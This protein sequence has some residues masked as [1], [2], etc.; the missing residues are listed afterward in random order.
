MAG[1]EAETALLR[2]LQKTFRSVQQEHGTVTKALAGVRDDMSTLSNQAEQYHTCKTVDIGDTALAGFADLQSG[3]L[4]KLLQNMQT[5]TDALHTAM[6]VTCIYS[7]LSI[8]KVCTHLPDDLESIFQGH[9]GSRSFAL[10]C[11]L[12]RECASSSSSFHY[13]DQEF[14]PALSFW[15]QEVGHLII[16]FPATKFSLHNHKSPTTSKKSSNGVD[17]PLPSN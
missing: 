6:Y 14:S 7:S 1:N 10:C 17:S 3:L 4:Q 8:V 16:C 9:S 15:A 5:C 12:D 13:Y 2:Q 11:L